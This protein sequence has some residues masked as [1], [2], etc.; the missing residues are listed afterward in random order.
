LTSEQKIKET[1]FFLETITT[2]YQDDEKCEYCIS[3][4]LHAGYD[5]IEH[6][7]E[8]YRQHFRIEIDDN[9]R[10]R[11][12]KFIALAKEK[13]HVDALG[14]IRLYITELHKIYTNPIAASLLVIRNSN[15]HR[16][17]NLTP[18]STFT[19]YQ[20]GRRDFDKRYFLANHDLFLPHFK[21]NLNGYICDKSKKMYKLAQQ[22][23][24]DVPFI[25]VSDTTNIYD[26]AGRILTR[27][28]VKVVCKMYLKSLE[29]FV[30]AIR[31]KYPRW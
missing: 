24:I 8:E 10:D 3:A 1:R 18:F 5:L 23:G 11:L 12:K 25:L 27:K 20:D 21:K 4:F 2:N 29:E 9:E 16:Q 30:I 17:T 22:T 26:E 19:E 31:A 7:F 14:F 6:T 28:D 13:Q 15:T